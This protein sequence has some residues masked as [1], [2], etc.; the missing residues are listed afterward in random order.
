MEEINKILQFIGGSGSGLGYGDGS[1]SGDGDGSGY[2][3]GDGSGYG[4]GDGYGDG[5]GYGLGDGDGDGSGSGLGDGSGSGSGYG[6]GDGDGSGYGDGDG[7]SIKIK[8]IG[9]DLVFYVDDI[10]TIIDKIRGNIAKGRIVNED[11][12]TV[13]KCYIAK[14]GSYFAH[15]NTIKKAVE[16]VQNKIYA[17][18][19]V[20]DRIKEFCNKFKN[21]IKYSANTFF[22]WHNILTGS[23]EAGRHQFIKS[24]NIDMQKKYS[25]KEFIAICENSYGGL[26]IKRLK[27]LYK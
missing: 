9:N 11:D 5:S 15:E 18:L 10:P 22:K 3:D 24:N 16:S 20:E 1:G 14:S 4:L 6:D 8:K 2:G 19:D 23:C 7:Y 13:T 25:V 26:I 12:F 17:D 27:E 21:K